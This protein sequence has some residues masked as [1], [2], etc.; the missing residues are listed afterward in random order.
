[1]LRHLKIKTKI[2]IRIINW[3]RIDDDKLLEKYKTVRTKN[4]DLKKIEFDALQVYD[5]RYIKTKIRTKVDKLTN[6]PGLNV[7]EDGV[8]CE[9]FTIISINSLFI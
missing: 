3:Y 2:G 6:L 1:M 8:E 7:Q 9:S 5:S 4:K